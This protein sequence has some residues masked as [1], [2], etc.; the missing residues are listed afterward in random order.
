MAVVM[1]VVTPS[2]GHT[3]CTLEGQVF[4]SPEGRSAPCR[5]Q[6]AVA[7]AAVPEARSKTQ[8]ASATC[9]WRTAAPLHPGPRGVRRAGPGSVDVAGGRPARCGVRA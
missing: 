4:S 3:W 7:S 5:P 1:A 6:S 2:L 9:K 8:V